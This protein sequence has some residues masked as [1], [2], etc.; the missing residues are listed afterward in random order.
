MK[1]KRY[2]LFWLKSNRGTN[3]K[4][5]FEIPPNW[6]KDRIKDELE[7]WCSGFGAWT[8]GD[9]I[10]NYGYKAVKIPNKRELLKQW[11]KLCKRKDAIYE[12]WLITREMFSPTRKF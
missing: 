4:H 9:N 12:K 2:I 8:H 3:Q 11:D 10:V 7:R 5:I 6:S 1:K